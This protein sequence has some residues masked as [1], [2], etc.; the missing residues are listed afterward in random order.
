MYCKAHLRQRKPSNQSWTSFD[1]IWR[2]LKSTLSCVSFSPSVAVVTSSMAQF[3][4]SDTTPPKVILSKDER[5][6][7]A[8]C[9]PSAILHFG[10][11]ATIKNY[12]K[13]D[14]LA[15]MSSPKAC[16]R[17]ALSDRGLDKTIS[18]PPSTEEIAEQSKA[19]TSNTVRRPNP[20]AFHTSGAMS[21]HDDVKAPKWFK[22]FG[23]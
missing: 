4:I 22:P 1:R 12:L 8:K 13:D 21:A 23:K 20:D 2:Y 5:L 7:E 16:L 17:I 15:K 10:T 14:V 18:G 9:V 19:G 3:S 11:N 6:F